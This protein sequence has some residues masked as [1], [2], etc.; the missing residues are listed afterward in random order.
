MRTGTLCKPTLLFS[1]ARC[2]SH[3]GR[4]TVAKTKAGRKR[5]SKTGRKRSRTYTDNVQQVIHPDR[6]ERQRTGG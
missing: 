5:A 4:S 1:T 2:K 3:G 6:N